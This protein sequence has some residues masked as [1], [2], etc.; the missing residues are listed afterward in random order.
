M[1]ENMKMFSRMLRRVVSWKL[2][3]FFIPTCPGYFI[4]F[5]STRFNHSN[6]TC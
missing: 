4:L 6:N 2:K 1:A 5:D 3:Y